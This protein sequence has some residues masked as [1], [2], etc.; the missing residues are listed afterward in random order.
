MFDPDVSPSDSQTWS[1]GVGKPM[2]CEVLGVWKMWLVP[3]VPLSVCL[4]LLLMTQHTKYL[5]LLT[6]DPWKSGNM[7]DIQTAAE[8]CLLSTSASGPESGLQ[9][10]AAGE[11]CH[12]TRSDTK[13][14]WAACA[15]LAKRVSL[16]DVL[17]PGKA[18]HC[19]FDMC[20]RH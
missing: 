12:E 1:G 16:K 14:K 2:V 7:G 8:V 13:E 19:F 9:I 17:E 11:Q 20:I 18:R 5:D 15:Q 6:A 10:K 3:L 4:V